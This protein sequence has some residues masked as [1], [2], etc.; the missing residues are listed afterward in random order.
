MKD[1]NVYTFIADTLRVKRCYDI[2]I[3]VRVSLC[4][5]LLSLLLVTTVPQTS[6]SGWIQSRKQRYARRRILQQCEHRKQLKLQLHRDRMLFRIRGGDS[7]PQDQGQNQATNTDPSSNRILNYAPTSASYPGVPPPPPPPRLPPGEGSEKDQ[8]ENDCISSDD[9]IS[10]ARRNYEA[11]YYRNKNTIQPPPPRQQH[12]DLEQRERL[13]HGNEDD[14]EMPTSEKSAPSPPPGKDSASAVRQSIDL[15]Q[16]QN[17]QAERNNIDIDEGG[18]ASLEKA[19]FV[20]QI[21]SNIQSHEE[22]NKIRPEIEKIQ[23]RHPDCEHR[24]DRSPQSDQEVSDENSYDGGYIQKENRT[25]KS[26]DQYTQNE[27]HNKE[28]VSDEN[29]NDIDS[30]QKENQTLKTLDQNVQNE[31]Q[32]Q[33]IVLDTKSV[34]TDFIQNKRQAVRSPYQNVHTVQD[35]EKKNEKKIL[36]ASSNRVEEANVDLA[37][38]SNTVTSIFKEEEN[39]VQNQNRNEIESNLSDSYNTMKVELSSVG[40]VDI[41]NGFEQHDDQKDAE[42][43]EDGQKYSYEEFEKEEDATS[44]ITND[45]DKDIMMDREALSKLQR[46]VEEKSTTHKPTSITSWVLKGVSNLGKR[47]IKSA[48]SGWEFNDSS[49]T[50]N[51][52]APK[53]IHLRS[54]E[55]KL[56]TEFSSVEMGS[57]VSSAPLLRLGNSIS[58][59]GGLPMESSWGSEQWVDHTM[60]LFSLYFELWAIKCPAPQKVKSKPVTTMEQ[61]ELQTMPSAISNMGTSLNHAESILISTFLSNAV[62]TAVMNDSILNSILPAVYN[63]I[64][65]YK[66]PAPRVV[67]KREKKV[68]TKT[69]KVKETI[70]SRID[71][72]ED[73][74]DIDFARLL[75]EL[76]GGPVEEIIEQIEYE[77][78]EE[79]LFLADEDIETEEIYEVDGPEPDDHIEIPEIDTQLID[80]IDIDDESVIDEGSEEDTD[81]DDLLE[82]EEL[83]LLEAA[84]IDESEWF[85]GDD[86]QYD[87][88][89]SDFSS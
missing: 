32:N 3:R 89:D 52:I 73:L 1:P 64:E 84:R 10:L 6:G 50:R 46:S 16:G 44:S 40:D 42:G 87:R 21:P 5:I 51:D 15:A 76:D 85:S 24:K 35:D 78:D 31:I 2:Q 77:Y 75:V 48:L 33:H 49:I 60:E 62:T 20:T 43:D 80:D 58:Y 72:D 71:P 9:N 65:N 19:H 54:Y 57:K 59:S 47:L 81:Y 14:H 63:H 23:N 83:E 37:K 12:L 66:P 27:I 18:S 69:T 45:R 53:Q 56:K 30:I 70:L 38:S 13:V 4:I 74:D 67:V 88:G 82:D 25:L 17:Q 22:K 28:V 7:A 29:S 41:S 68:I 36:S 11:K 86:E 39:G 26:E 79:P 55:L 34:D 61:R 8:N